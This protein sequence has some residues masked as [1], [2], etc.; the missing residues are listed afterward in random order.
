MLHF[1]LG[2]ALCI[3]IGERLVHYWWIMKL[4]REERREE[5]RILALYAPQQRAADFTRYEPEQR[6]ADHRA[7]KI[8]SAVFI[9]AASFLA[10]AMFG[11]H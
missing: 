1:L 2:L 3:F 10:V 6:T 8:F 11:P 7:L 4:R 9:A 5:R